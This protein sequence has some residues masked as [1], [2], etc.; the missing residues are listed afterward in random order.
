MKI[1]FVWTGVTS[2][3][4]DC[5]RRLAAQPG[6]E[7][8]VVV[9]DVDSGKE[10]D[11]AQVLAGLDDDIEGW[12]PDVMFAVGWHSRVV[13]EMVSRQDWS[14]IPK[15]CCFDM[16]WRRSL[17]CIAAR[18]VLRPFLRNYAAAYVPGEICARYARWL[19]FRDVRTGLFSIDMERFRA[20]RAD[21]THAGFLYVG[22]MSV[23]KRVDLIEAAY[24]RYRELGGSWHIDYCGGV[25]FVRPEDMPRVYAAHACLVLASAFDP[26][27]LV[28]LEAKSAGCDVIMSDRCGNRFEIEARVVRFGD[29]DGVAR[30]MLAVERGG[31]TT[32]NTECTGS[33][34]NLGRYDCREWA[35][36]TLAFA[37]ELIGGGG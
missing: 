32:K 31:V 27:P 29:V 8:K 2:Y 25:N 4:A 21:G 13:R 9:E 14:G 3:M 18:W 11:R 17:R 28:V 1:L 30:E 6:V 24:Q 19:G 23:E 37:K 34:E 7:L 5:W 20:A 33:S 35:V 22:R 15:V 12:R 36:R 26:W 16:P 10:F